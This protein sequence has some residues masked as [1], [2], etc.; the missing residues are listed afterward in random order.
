MYK[1]S[2]S[3]SAME[4]LMTYGWAILVI[5]IVIAALFGLNIFSPFEFSP[6]ASPGSCYVSKPDIYGSPIP[7]SLVGGG[8]SEIPEYVGVFNNSISVTLNQLHYTHEINSSGTSGV[9][10]VA[11]SSSQNNLDSYT[12]VELGSPDPSLQLGDDVHCGFGST[13]GL[14]IVYYSS[15]SYS[16][17]CM[18]E[19]AQ[20]SMEFYAF[21]FNGV[22][23]RGYQSYDGKLYNASFT[24]S[25]GSN[26]IVSDPLITMGGSG[27]GPFYMSNVQ[28]Y[29]TSLSNSSIQ[30]LYQEGIGGAPIDLQNLVGWWPLD[31]NANDYSGNGNNGA[32]TNVK[33]VSNWESGYSAP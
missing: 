25:M 7:P 9:T 15:P 27:G 18:H 12:M 29:N 20:N 31:G 10:I 14:I 13:G 33:Y 8:C 6:K 19:V 5:A 11:W 23:G 2:R 30:A 4:Y 3:Q 17:N 16:D 24:A 26:S 22:V 21:T 28:I 32:A 1:A